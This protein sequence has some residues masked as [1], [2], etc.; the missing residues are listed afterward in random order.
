MGNLFA[1]LSNGNTSLLYY[2]KGIET[3]GHNLANASTEGFSR[4]RVNVSENKPLSEGNGYS[5][6]Q[7]VSIDSITRVRNEF[8]DAQFRAQ[9][10]TLG[11]WQTRVDAINNLEYYSGQIANGNL[12]SAID[13]F[14]A[15]MQDVSLYPDVS[16]YRR[17]LVESAKTMVS[18]LTGIRTQY[19]AYRSYINEE[20]YNM[21]EEANSLIDDIALLCGDIYRA[22]GK[23]EN[24][25]DLL[26]KRDLLA[27]RLCKLTGATVSSPAL[28]EA[29]GDYKIDLHGKNLVQGAAEFNCKGTEIKNTRHLILVPM[30][31]NNSYYDVQVEYDQ[32]D[33]SSNYSVASGVMERSA[34]MPTCLNPKRA[35]EL[36]VERLANGRTWMVGGALGNHPQSGDAGER[37]DTIYDKNE[38]LGIEGSFSL[39]VGTVGV[40]VSSNSYSTTNTATNGIVLK[41]P[42][43]GSGDPTEYEFRIAAGAFESTVKVKYDSGTAKWNI[44]AIDASGTPITLLGA[45]ATSDLKVQELSDALKAYPSSLYPQQ[46]LSTSYDS[47]AELFTSEAANSA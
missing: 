34:V 40:Q 36:F 4:Q 25:N 45:S 15:K 24:P 47:S 18:S 13:A 1:G 12:G 14:W 26:D 11:Y 44:T 3:A 27:E 41:A 16:T 20:I 35:H 7:G 43:A 29:D 39:Q 28:D 9:L 42:V 22:Q 21:V 46:P 38:A 19:D 37:L 5:V 23:G 32:F 30:V 10:P 33:H 8:L 6:G 17:T 31:G 2:R